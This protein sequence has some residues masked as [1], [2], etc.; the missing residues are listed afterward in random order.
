[1]DEIEVAVIGPGFGEA[2]LVHIGDGKWIVVDSCQHPDH[3]QAAPLEYLE[4]LGYEASEAIV[5][6]VATHYD[7][8]HIKG[9]SQVV[10][11]APAAKYITAV[12][13]TQGD[14]VK[15]AKVV[16]NDP[17]RIRGTGLDEFLTILSHFSENRRAITYALPNRQIY[18]KNSL[19]FSHGEPFE[20]VTLSPADREMTTFLD[21]LAQQMPTAGMQKGHLPKRIRN[22]L[23]VALLITIGPIAILLG[24]D[25][26]EEGKPDTG[27]SSVLGSRGQAPWPR[28]AVFKVAHH[29]SITGHHQNV[30]TDMLEGQPISILAPWFNGAAQL[31][32]KEDRDRIVQL[33]GG[34]YSTATTRT[35]KADKRS[36]AVERTIRETVGE[37]RSVE[38]IPGLVR[39]RTKAKNLEDGW[40]VELFDGAI[41][42]SAWPTPAPEKA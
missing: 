27:W 9:L 33:S 22:D 28:A 6:I 39:A 26:E 31:P 5:A 13:M 30:W 42:L 11:A 18:I 32:T 37:L 35:K 29:G 41:E 12:P 10:E 4:S 19:V 20:M 23:S 36:P 1:M 3:V 16:G 40:V 25:L 7:G 34:A 24:A 15:F 8:D 21:W 17:T 2:I 14:F 38:S